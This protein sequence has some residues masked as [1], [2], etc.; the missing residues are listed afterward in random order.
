MQLAGYKVMACPTSKVYHVG[1]G[2]LPKG[3][4]RKV[5][6]NF[7]NNLIMLAKN[8]PYGELWWKIPFRIVLDMVSAWKSLFAGEATYFIAVLEAHFGFLRWLFFAK[9]RSVFPRGRKGILHGYF[10]GSVVWRHFVLGKGTFSEIVGNI[11]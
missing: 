5:Y 6:L 10:P 8:L 11:E 3:N 2:T 4:E 7:R 9:R 1:G